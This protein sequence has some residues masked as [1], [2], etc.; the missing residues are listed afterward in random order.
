[1]KS[2][3]HRVHPMIDQLL[4]S[5]ALVKDH[6]ALASSDV[7]PHTVPLD[8]GGEDPGAPP[9]ADSPADS[10]GFGGDLSGDAPSADGPPIDDGSGAYAGWGSDGSPPAW[11]GYQPP[12]MYSPPPVDLPP[13]EPVDPV[14]PPA[15]P[16]GGVQ[17]VVIGVPEPDPWAGV[18]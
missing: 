1:M 10:G 7:M 15:D 14:L 5:L 8:E 13:P 6:H 12:P 16:Y 18:A 2:H 4:V 11:W 9:P 3:P 17:P